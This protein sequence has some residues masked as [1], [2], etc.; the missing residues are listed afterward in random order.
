MRSE[1]KAV[2]E[3][4][5]LPDQTK[6]RIGVGNWSAFDLEMEVIRKAAERWQGELRGVER[7]WIC[8]NVDPDW[9]LVQQRLVTEVGWTPVIGGDPRASKPQLVKGAVLI[10]FNSDFHFPTMWMHFPLEF[11]FLFADRLAFWHSDL[12]VRL[13]KLREIAAIFAS[14]PDGSMAATQP[15]RRISQIFKKKD[16]R[17]WELIGCTTRGASRSQFENG[18]GWWMNFAAH[19]NCSSN[20]ERRRR[21]ALFWDHGVGIRYWAKN[22]GGKVVTLK[23]QLIA[24]GHCTR[25][26]NSRYQRLSPDN[27]TRLLPNEL[28]HNFDLAQVCHAL[29]LERLLEE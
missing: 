11:T 23:E 27:A 5:T 21:Q 3:G 14:L 12:L 2:T 16:L 7:P 8:W 19:P 15:R 18:C 10:D 13:E 24:E 29:G 6:Y 17:Y 4:S 26:G 9:C 22:C 25:I 28:R 20:E 1:E